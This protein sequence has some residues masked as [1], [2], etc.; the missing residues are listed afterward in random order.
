MA[1][2]TDLRLSDQQNLSAPA[3]IIG[4]SAVAFAEDEDEEP[5]PDV[6]A[7]N[8][9][10]LSPPNP[11]FLIDDNLNFTAISESESGSQHSES[12]HS[13]Q[14]F[15]Y[16]SP[17]D[18]D[19]DDQMNFVTDLFA[20]RHGIPDHGL[21]NFES[22]CTCLD[23]EPELVLGAQA[24]CNG[25]AALPSMVGGLRIV[26]MESESDSEAAEIHSRV[27]RANDHDGLNPNYDD[28]DEFWDC[29]QFD[30]QRART[31]FNEEFEWEEVNVRE[32]LSSLIDRIEE[33]SVSSDTE[34]STFDTGGGEHDEE[35][36]RNVEWQVLLAV[37]NL[38]IAVGFDEY[39]VLFGEHV[40][41]EST[42][43]GGPPAAKSVVE[44]LPSVVL[45]TEDLMANDV[46]CAV[47]KDE[48]SL[49]VEVTRLPCSHHYHQDCIMPWLSIRNTCPLCRFELP[50]DDVD[51]ERRKNRNGAG[52]SLIGDLQFSNYQLLP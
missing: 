4:D 27:D 52:T 10:S 30:S 16:Y 37:N 50:T 29:P 44:N 7:L 9:H 28:L 51:Y 22:G 48:I 18:D 47:C 32:N 36:A 17:E 35:N 34:N 25:V 41:A 33:I 12:V 26:N 24:E 2:V 39:I 45:T 42:V 20:T 46:V 40:D 6:Y 38:E 49:G 14:N 8:F 43:K 1:E 21:C 5:Q 15:L 31:F 19:D 3:T 11:S 23:E 13:D